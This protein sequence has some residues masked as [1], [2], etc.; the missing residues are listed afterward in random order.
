M[1]Q[2]FRAEREL[3]HLS[4]L[5]PNEDAKA[6]RGKVMF[7]GPPCEPLSALGLQASGRRSYFCHTFL[8]PSITPG[9]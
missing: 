4:F 9:I 6:Q 5:Y 3:I 7:P 2:Y 8:P 1:F